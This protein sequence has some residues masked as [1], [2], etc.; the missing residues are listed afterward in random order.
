MHSDFH[1][2]LV[3]QSTHIE[4]AHK[5]SADSDIRLISGKSKIS[6]SSGRFSDYIIL[7]RI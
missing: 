3:T 7:R 2:I 6:F 5:K 4:Q 1:S